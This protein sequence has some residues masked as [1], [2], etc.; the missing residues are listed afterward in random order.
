MGLPTYLLGHTIY[1]PAN[2][3]AEDLQLWSKKH[4]DEE[5]LQCNMAVIVTR[6]WQKL[7]SVGWRLALDGWW[8]Q[9]SGVDLPPSVY[10]HQ[11]SKTKTTKLILLD[12]LLQEVFIWQWHHSQRESCEILRVIEY[13]DTDW[14]GVFQY[15]QVEEKL[16]YQLKPNTFID[17]FVIYWHTI[18]SG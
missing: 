8:P 10:R 1:Y 11:E 17:K 7:W 5:Y 2:L 12:S 6:P 4:E 13:R 16:I 18:I 3:L 15:R 14:F 9:S